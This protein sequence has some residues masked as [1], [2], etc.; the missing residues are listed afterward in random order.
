[1]KTSNMKSLAIA[2]S[3]I[4]IGASAMAKDA[5][6][7]PSPSNFP[8]EHAAIRYDLEMARIHKGELRCLKSELK[9]DRKSGYA[10]DVADDKREIKVAK[11]ALSESKK[12]LRADTRELKHNYRL[13]ILHRKERIDAMRR[14]KRHAEVDLCKMKRYG[15][16]ASVQVAAD[17]VTVITILHDASVVSLAEFKDQRKEDMVAVNE[18]IREFKPQIANIVRSH[19]RDA[20]AGSCVVR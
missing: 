9:A 1:M 10:M 7:A 16:D 5:G 6:A 18:D 15:N 14:D 17:Y 3:L 4:A 11:T 13:A 12:A 2:L 19:D 8:R 20:Y